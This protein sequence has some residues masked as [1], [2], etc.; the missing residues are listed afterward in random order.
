MSGLIRLYP[1]AW[2]ERYGEE[3]LAL[4]EA[5]PPT[6]GDRFDIVR[7]AI[8]ARLHPQVRQASPEPAGP[9]DQRA[10]DLV[11]AR[12]LGFGALA[13][14][15]VWAAAWGVALMGPLI[16]D[17][18]GA[19]RDGAAA[20]PV[21]MLAV[22]LLV[23]GLIGQLIWLPRS[24]RAARVGAVIAIPCLIMWSFGPWLIQPFTIAVVGLVTLSIGA[25]RVGAWSAAPALAVAA[26]PVLVV[27]A[28][29][30]GFSG[31]LELPQ[32]VVTIVILVLGLPIWLGVGGT[33]TA[34]AAPV[35]MRP[36]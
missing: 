5:R 6:P 8:D 3:F 32:D 19:Y 13:G 26:S 7:G 27:I 24:A 16:Y 18:Y 15:G 36:A 35:R 31:L 25:V 17:G 12:R 21:I 20:L 34:G 1:A 9:P 14:A 33:L 22:A 30:L 11:V 28:V 2:R 4:L 10:A 23:G 29:F